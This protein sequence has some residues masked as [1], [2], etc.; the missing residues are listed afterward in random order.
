MNNKK[1]ASIASL[2]NGKSQVQLN[3]PKDCHGHFNWLH[4]KTLAKSTNIHERKI[5]EWLEINNRDRGNIVTTNSWESLFRTINM[6]RHANVMK[7][8]LFRVHFNFIIY[9][10]LCGTTK[11]PVS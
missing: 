10:Y 7:K 9:I 4:P 6:A 2:E 1:I 5:R 8:M 3:I 11:K